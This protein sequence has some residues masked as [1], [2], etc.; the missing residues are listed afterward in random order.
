MK[1]IKQLAD[2]QREGKPKQLINKMRQQIREE[3]NKW[4][5]KTA[6]EGKATV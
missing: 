4:E 5:K 1:G 2:T 3:A 6:L